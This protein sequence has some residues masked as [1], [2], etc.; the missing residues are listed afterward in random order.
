M[1]LFQLGEASYS[2]AFPLCDLDHGIPG[3]SPITFVVAPQSSSGVARSHSQPTISEN[4]FSIP[5]RLRRLPSW[6][7]VS[8]AASWPEV[9]CQQRS[10][11]LFGP[12]TIRA[13][14][15]SHASGL[16]SRNRWSITSAV[17]RSLS[18]GRFAKR[19]VWC[20]GTV[21]PSATAKCEYC[22]TVPTPLLGAF[23]HHGLRRRASWPRTGR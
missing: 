22:R 5:F 14:L 3:S 11:A 15:Q 4:F 20:P 9:D 6:T 16:A 21:S 18:P 13:R 7:A 10:R 19:S 12:E 1:R 17:P 23:D 8:V 2:G